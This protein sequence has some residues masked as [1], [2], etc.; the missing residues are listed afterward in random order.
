[1]N[2]CTNCKHASFML[3]CGSTNLVGVDVVTGNP[4]RVSCWDVKLPTCAHWEAR[5]APEA[6][7]A[8]FAKMKAALGRVL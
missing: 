3:T 6:A 1:M 5:P 2:K 7:P 8:L 4:K